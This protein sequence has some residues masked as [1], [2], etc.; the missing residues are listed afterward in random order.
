[1]QRS[2][3]L[4]ANRRSEHGVVERLLDGRLGFH[5]AFQPVVDLRHGVVTGY[6]ALARFPEELGMRPDEVFQLAGRC[7]RRPELEAR[8][9]IAALEERP[10]LPRNCFLSVNAGPALLLSKGWDG[11]LA[12]AGRLDAVVV[13]VTE[14]EPVLDYGLLRG[15]LDRIRELGG[16]VAV[17]DTGTG[18]AS[19]KHVMELRP[20]FIKLDRFFVGGC[21]R[22]PARRAMIEM[23]GNVASRLDAWIVAEGVETTDELEEL[24]KLGVPLAQGFYLGR[25]EPAMQQLAAGMGDTLRLRAAA[26]GANDLQRILE[27]CGSCAE[28]GEGEKQLEANPEQRMVALTDSWGRPVGL[29]ERHPVLGSRTIEQPMKAQMASEAHE[30]LH[31]ALTRPLES[32]FDPIAV[33]NEQ[34]GFEGVVV[35]DRLM[36]LALEA[37]VA[38]DAG[39]APRRLPLPVPEKRRVRERQVECR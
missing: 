18:Y 36:R 29:M 26:M 16:H 13:E 35:T 15:R 1:M 12:R 6:E 9:V 34:G 17:D 37:K 2:E 23:L 32:R 11:V 24:L 27:R 30:V 3:I 8:A 39:T 14:D 28:Q 10:M 22:E 33:I 31:R 4:R 21:N 20:N 19:L 25:P 7:G 5:F 38:S